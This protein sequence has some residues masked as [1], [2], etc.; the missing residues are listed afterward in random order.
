MSGIDKLFD[1]MDAWRHLPNYQLERRAGLFF[2]LYLTEALEAKLGFKIHWQC[3]RKLAHVMRFSGGTGCESSSR[4][5]DVPLNPNP[6]DASV[7]G[8]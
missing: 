3:P 8:M 7:T 4:R 2:S 5:L 1:C 6:E